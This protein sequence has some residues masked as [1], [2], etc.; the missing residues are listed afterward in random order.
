MGFLDADED[1]PFGGNWQIL[2]PC[3]EL[4]NEDDGCE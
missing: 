4:R 2:L 1:P 3:A